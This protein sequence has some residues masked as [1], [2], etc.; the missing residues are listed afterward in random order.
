MRFSNLV[1]WQAKLAAKLILSRL[2]IP[3]S[4]WRRLGIFRHGA[5]DSPEY[6]LATF[7]AHLDGVHAFGFVLQGRTVLELGPG[8]TVATGLIA[9]V[10][11][12]NQCVLIDTGPYA[13]TDIRA[14]VQILEYLETHGLIGEVPRVEG[15]SQ[16]LRNWHV[17]YL[18]EGLQSLREVPSTSIDLIV[19]QAVLE[20][21]RLSEF[22]AIQGEL[23]RVLRPGGFVSHVIDLKDHLGG[24]LNNLRFS[25][26][27]WERDWMAGSGFYTNRIRYYD[28]LR[29]FSSAGYE[30]TSQ[31]TDRWHQLPT[32]RVRLH[33][34]F[35][36]LPE[37][38]LNVRGLRVV[39]RRGFDQPI[40]KGNSEPGIAG[41]APA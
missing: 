6:A 35:R 34:Q 5:M 8:D 30:I 39:L 22:D 37:E 25:P 19:S 41:H 17:T 20:H 29:R 15:F 27:L 36:D 2:G 13:R 28:M 9:S 26:G 23:H 32:P 11:G 1:P 40:L 18:T 3:Y 12:A 24:G 10:L 31:V 33:E 38:D 4:A 21:L 14:Y 16:L 7:K